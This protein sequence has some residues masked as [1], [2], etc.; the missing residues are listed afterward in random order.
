M[1]APTPLAT[2]PLNATMGNGPAAIPLERQSQISVV[3]VS[4]AFIIVPTIALV[5]RL[6]ARRMAHRALDASDYCIIVACIFSHALQLVS[7]LSVTQGG[8]GYLFREIIPKHGRGP[9]IKFLQLLVVQQILW[10]VSL[11]LCKI[12]IL[13][14]YTKLFSVRRM[15]LAARI[16][17]LF[18]VIWTAVAVLVAFFIC[19]PLSDNWL[20]D[21]KNRNCGNQPAADGTLGVV[22]LMTDIIVLLMP[23]SY[24]WSLQ[25]ERFKKIA[26]IATFSLGIFTCIVSALRLYYLAN[27]KYTDVTFGIPN[28]LI[29]SALEPGVGIT[30]ACIPFLRPLLG[31]SNYSPKGTARYY[32]T[33]ES[34]DNTGRRVSGRNGLALVGDDSSGHP[35]QDY[36]Q[37]DSMPSFPNKTHTRIGSGS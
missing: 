15:V 6:I 1:A 4:I 11:S 26:L 24:L 21:L 22:N 19:I 35:L 30:L 14:L 37:T 33:V 23:V 13:H 5:L 34:S 7:I 12:S 27:L 31:R 28:A 8:V 3:A 2:A 16:M 9:I 20:L 17:A 18:T 36:R 25:L 32:T 10:A 29:F